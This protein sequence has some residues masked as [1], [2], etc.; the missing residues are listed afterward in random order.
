MRG[1]PP[2]WPWCLVQSEGRSDTTAAGSLPYWRLLP[3]INRLY[4][5]RH[6]YGFRFAQLEENRCPHPRH[7][8]RRAAWCK[9]PA[10]AMALLHGISGRPCSA[11]LYMDTDAVISNGSLSIDDWLARAKH[12]RKDEA[13]ADDGWLLLA[14]SNYWHEPDDLNSGVFVL[15]GGERASEPSPPRHWR[16]VG[17]SGQ[18]ASHCQV[19]SAR[20]PPMAAALPRLVATPSGALGLQALY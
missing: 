15:R 3:R 8:R 18:I 4:S 6:G 19:L 5:V 13:L 9:I 10:V 12:E 17:L 16:R 7:G 14:S 20:R 11:V 1:E 2:P